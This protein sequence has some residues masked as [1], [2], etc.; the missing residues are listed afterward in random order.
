MGDIPISSVVAIMGEDSVMATLLDTNTAD[1]SSA[2]LHAFTTRVSAS[3]KTLRDKTNTC[4][5]RCAPYLS[6]LS[7]RKTTQPARDTSTSSASRVRPASDAP[8]V[9]NGLITTP[10]YGHGKPRKANKN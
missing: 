3:Y 10:G 2:T 4:V 8:S 1:M 7:E 9:P 6:V 5:E